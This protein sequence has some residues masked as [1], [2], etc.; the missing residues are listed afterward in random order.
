[1]KKYQLA[2]LFYPI[3][4]TMDCS[5]QSDKTYWITKDVTKMDGKLFHGITSSY[6]EMI[7]EMR[8]HL[9]KNSDSL[10]VSYPFEKKMK[11]SE[12]K[13]LT[14]VRIRESGELLDSIYEVKMEGDLL[15]IKFIY[16]GTSDDEKSFS[17]NLIQVNKDKFDQEIAQLKKNKEKLLGSVKPVNFSNLDLALAVPSYFKAKNIGNAINPVQLAE[18][19]ADMNKD[20]LPIT[21]ITTNSSFESEIPGQ[22][23]E[24][25]SVFA[26]E[27]T[28]KINLP[29]ANVGKTNFNSIELICHSTTEDLALILLTKNAKGDDLQFLYKAISSNLPNAKIETKGLPQ[30]AS[31]KEVIDIDDFITISFI[32]ERK[33]IKLS[34]D[35]SL[36]YFAKHASDD[37]ILAYDEQ[38]PK[39]LKKVFEHYLNLFSEAKVRLYIVSKSFDEVLKMDE[40]LF[41]ERTSLEDYQWR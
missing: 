37:V 7:A 33:I 25:Y 31:D 11:I 34:I 23:K 27:N 36:D 28:E 22:T 21:Q 12:F 40:K 8:I 13:S 35:V 3:F 30:Y 41:T 4:L 1:M 15:K 24:N 17:V 32:N 38:N 39:A 19:L 6:M 2:F 26:L 9:I 5:Q 29:V 16:A 14:N 18:E 10:I 20:R